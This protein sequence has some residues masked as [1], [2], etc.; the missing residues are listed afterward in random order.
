MDEM[1][2]LESMLCELDAYAETLDPE[3]TTYWHY[4]R[5]RF[6]WIGRLFHELVAEFRWHKQPIERVLDIGNSY[7]TLLFN[8]LHPELRIDTLGWL[9]ERYAPSGDSTH[10]DFDLNNSY[11]QEKDS[12]PPMEGGYQI[13]AFLEVVEHLYTSPRVVFSFLRELM[14]DGGVLI[15]Q[16]PN[17]AAL[18]K[19]LRLLRGGNP[20]ELIREDRMNP[21]HF[22]EYTVEELCHLGHES[23]LEVKDIHVTN[24]FI[25]GAWLDRTCD[26]L[27]N[28]LPKT[29]R[30][31]MT[32]VF[33]K[34]ADA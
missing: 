25:D 29:F 14:A 33:R 8:R 24:F 23:G 13:I 12:W 31:G 2:R 9:C 20:Y 19:R 1:D 16:T 3:S 5:D 6:A 18:K 15:V 21:G 28:Y 34:Q 30:S 27:A 22:R 32:V 4:H 26:R 17:A 11:T 7:Q 10:F